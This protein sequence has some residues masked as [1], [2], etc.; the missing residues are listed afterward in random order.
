[1]V[2]GDFGSADGLI[3]AAAPV[4]AFAFEVS[5]SEFEFGDAGFE[6]D[7][8]LLA[9]SERR[10]EEACEGVA[11]AFEHVRRPAPRHVV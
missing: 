9:R 11:E 6:D 2:F 7:A 3:D 8:G 5:G 4:V 10:A 1:L